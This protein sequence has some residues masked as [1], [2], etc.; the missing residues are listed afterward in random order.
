MLKKNQVDI[1]KACE[2]L[3]NGG[4]IVYPTDTIYGIGCDAKNDKAIKKINNLKGRKSPISVLAPN[5][6]TAMQ[7]ITVEK[8]YHKMI[9]K[10]LGSASTII[11][12]VKNGIV[13]KL[14]MGEKNSLGIRIPENNFCYQLSNSYPNPITTTSVNRTGQPPLTNPNQIQNEFGNKIDLIIN[15]GIIEGKSSKIYLF[16]KNKL[17]QIR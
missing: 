10:K 7:W 2:I 11:A 5:K 13:S 3:K 14:I 6:H 12:P 9:S 4:L 16:N 1:I 8:I 15:A 17:K